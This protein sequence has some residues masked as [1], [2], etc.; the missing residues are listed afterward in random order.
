MAGTLKGSYAELEQRVAERTEELRDSNQALSAL[1]QRSALAILAI[2]SD[3]TLRMW[4]P[5]AERLLGWSP[6]EVIGLP[7][8]QILTV[9]EDEAIEA[10]ASLAGAL[11]GDILD[12]VEDRH[13][14]KDGT[15]VDVGIWT[16]PLLD[17]TGRVTGVMS[18]ITDLTT[19]KE[20]E[21]TVRDLAVLEERNRM[22]REIHDTMAQGFTGIVLQLEAAEQ[23]FDDSGADT[24]DHLNRAKELARECLQEAM[25]AAR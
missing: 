14:R 7:L 19:R 5:A 17:A 11:R 12:G 10:Q 1:I 21:Q 20:A 8:R 4:N 22:A 3:T 6:D 23:A 25:E 13:I 16:A 18:L 9:P 24:I 15:S 2:Q